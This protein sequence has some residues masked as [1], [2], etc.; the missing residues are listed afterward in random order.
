MISELDSKALGD[1]SEL[2]E[3]MDTKERTYG[4][5]SGG[6]KGVDVKRVDDESVDFE[7]MDIEGEEDGGT[8][9]TRFARTLL[10]MR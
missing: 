5:G 3:E 2:L 10:V 4:K 6:V 9:Q 8:R 1:G 7:G